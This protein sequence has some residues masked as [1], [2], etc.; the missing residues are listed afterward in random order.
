M[1]TVN[2]FNTTDLAG[3][4]GWAYGFVAYMNDGS[5]VYGPLRFVNAANQE[6]ELSFT[7]PSGVRRLLVVVQGSPMV[8]RQCPWDEKEST[9]DQLPYLYKID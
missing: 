6:S 7:V 2:H 8:Y 4:E 9:D 3:N 5:R 1:A